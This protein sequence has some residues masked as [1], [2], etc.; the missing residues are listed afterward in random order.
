MC[1]TESCTA[2]A[3]LSEIVVSTIVRHTP[4]SIPSELWHL[5]ICPSKHPSYVICDEAMRHYA[6]YFIQN[7]SFEFRVETG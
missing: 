2:A 5:K 6:K 7:M 3:S 4:K 1:Q